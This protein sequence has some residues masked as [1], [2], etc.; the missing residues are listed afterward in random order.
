[1]YKVSKLI[2]R[3][4]ALSSVDWNSDPVPTDNGLTNYLSGLRISSL[5]SGL[6]CGADIIFAK[7]SGLAGIY[8]D[9]SQ[10][11]SFIAQTPGS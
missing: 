7:L 10:C 11:G 1:M 6:V 8:P 3:D 2:P 4:D 9:G 5:D